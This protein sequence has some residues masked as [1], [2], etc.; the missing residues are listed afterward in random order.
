[1]TRRV[2]MSK[3]CTTISSQRSYTYTDSPCSTLRTIDLVCLLVLS[4]LSGVLGIKLLSHIL[5]RRIGDEYG[6]IMKTYRESNLLSTTELWCIHRDK[7]GFDTT[8]LRMLYELLGNFPVLIH[9][10]DVGFSYCMQ[11]A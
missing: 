8:L 1:M 9:I 7:E 4:H 10:P 2:D 3:E 6:H 5:R 11:K